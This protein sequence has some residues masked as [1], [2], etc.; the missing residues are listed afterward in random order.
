MNLDW[1]ALLAI[2]IY[3]SC[4]IDW[5]L[6][7]CSTCVRDTPM[8]GKSEQALGGGGGGDSLERGRR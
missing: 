7:N 1:E 3:L 5:S 4:A 2:D 6:A 8:G